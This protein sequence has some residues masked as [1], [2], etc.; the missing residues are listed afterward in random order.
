MHARPGGSSGGGSSFGLSIQQGPAPAPAP[1]IAILEGGAPGPAPDRAQAAGL[2]LNVSRSQLFLPP[3]RTAFDGSYAGYQG[4]LHCCACC[5]MLGWCMVFAGWWQ[6]E[7]H[8]QLR[9]WKPPGL[10]AKMSGD[11]W[12]RATCCGCFAAQPHVATQLHV[13]SALPCRAT[14]SALCLLGTADGD[15]P[16]PPPTAPARYDA[17]ADFG[18]KGDGEADD[19]AALQVG[20]AEGQRR[21]LAEHAES[22][23]G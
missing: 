9:C 13:G 2:P 1:W 6:P 11:G 21:G 22:K 19:T 10:G 18:A 15:V 7:G 23:H 8:V 17:Q 3:G 5:V 12:H 16:L 20:R 14:I 4:G